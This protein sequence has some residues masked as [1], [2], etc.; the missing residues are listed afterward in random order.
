[1]QS[2]YIVISLCYN[3]DVYD[4]NRQR[5]RAPVTINA[6]RQSIKLSTSN[7]SQSLLNRLF[8][9]Q[10]NS[11]SVSYVSVASGDYIYNNQR[12]SCGIVVRVMSCPCGDSV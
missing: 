8:T 5:F 6:D 10:P 3:I 2:K 12:S 11:H 9:V 1:M 4:K 7:Y